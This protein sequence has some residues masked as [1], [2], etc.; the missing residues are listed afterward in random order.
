MRSMW[1]ATAAD[2]L[3]QAGLSQGVFLSR[4][5]RFWGVGESSLAERMGDW[6]DSPNPTVAPYAGT[7]EVT[8]RITARAEDAA[9]ATRLLEPAEADLRQRSGTDLYGADGDSLASV[10][11]DLL[12]RPNPARA[13]ASG[14]LWRRC[15]VPPTSSSAG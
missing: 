6:L 10:V 4:T 15:P 14:P 11:L 9:A 13:V 12:R 5:L 3:R 7:G 2:W 1:E 8:L